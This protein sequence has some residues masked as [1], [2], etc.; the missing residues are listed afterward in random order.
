VA[1]ASTH[2]LGFQNEVYLFR[3]TGKTDKTLFR[4]GETEVLPVL[5]AVPLIQW[6]V[7]GLERLQ[8]LI[9]SDS[10]TAWTLFRPPAKP[11]KLPEGDLIS[12]TYNYP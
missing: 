8:A 4:R 7:F 12:N 9:N 3:T 2:Q 6:S 5:P 1:V 11:A 10:K